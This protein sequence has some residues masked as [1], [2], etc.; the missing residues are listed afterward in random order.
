MADKKILE[1]VVGVLDKKYVEDQ[2]KKYG[3]VHPKINKNK[4]TFDDISPFKLHPTYVKKMKKEYQKLKAIKFGSWPSVDFQD[5]F[6]KEES[7]NIIGTNKSIFPIKQNYVNLKPRFDS[8]GNFI[9]FKGSFGNLQYN[10]R[11]N[12]YHL[13]G[14]SLLYEVN[15]S[16]F[17][18]GGSGLIE[19]FQNEM[20]RGF[21]SWSWDKDNYVLVYDKK[22]A[23]ICSIVHK[24]EISPSDKTFVEK[25]ITS[26]EKATIEYWD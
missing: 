15:L 13:E 24:P 4:F 26:F 18:I 20:S 23:R 17:F 2:M 12:N 19:S 5:I 8:S 10:C 11:N 6:N 7:K 1:K 21:D 25:V 22:T 3:F 16:P 14:D 9:E